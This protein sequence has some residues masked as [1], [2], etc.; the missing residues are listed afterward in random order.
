MARSSSSGVIRQYPPIM[1]ITADHRVPS[2]LAASDGTGCLR[3][4]QAADPD[5]HGWSAAER[6]EP[7]AALRL[8]LSPAQY[9]ATPVSEI[10]RSGVIPELAHDHG[11]TANLTR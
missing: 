3:C 6:S 2:E 1:P 9:P 5:P 4:P 11:L 10:T 8:A 7:P